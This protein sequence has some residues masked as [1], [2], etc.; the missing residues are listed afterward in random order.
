MKT[1]KSIN[2]LFNAFQQKRLIC[3]DGHPFPDLVIL[4]TTADKLIKLIG[5]KRVTQ[6]LA[7]HIDID[8]TFDSIEHRLDQIEE[9]LG[10]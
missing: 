4:Q 1:V 7:H 10:L 3:L 2:E 8:K 9:V 6:K 5:Q